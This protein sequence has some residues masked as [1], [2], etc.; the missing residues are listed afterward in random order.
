MSKF[1]KYVFFTSHETRGLEC[2]KS[3]RSNLDLYAFAF[4][5]INSQLAL[6]VLQIRE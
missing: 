3:D 6:I 5:N 4:K 2:F 1:D